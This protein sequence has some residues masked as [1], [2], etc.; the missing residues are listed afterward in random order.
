[1]RRLVL[2]LVVLG[3]VASGCAQDDPALEGEPDATTEAT[4]PSE[5]SGEI[6]YNDHGTKSFTTE[7]VDLEMELDDFYFEPTFVKLPGDATIQ[8]TLH[9][10]GDAAHTFTSDTLDIDQE[11]GPGTT[12]EVELPVGTET[13]YEFWCR[14]HKGQGMRG[15]IQPH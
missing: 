9:N 8:L 13:R 4:A 12:K 11:V 3:A 2:I 7:S 5:D 14:F 10:E 6:E 1:M 15:A